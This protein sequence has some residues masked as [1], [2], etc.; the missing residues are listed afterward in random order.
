[1]LNRR[2]I[3]GILIAICYL[4]LSLNTAHSSALKL[5]SDNGD[6][7]IGHAIHYLDDKKY[8][9][10]LTAENF[11]DIEIRSLKK[12]HASQFNLVN[13]DSGYWLRVDLVSDV[14]NPESW[15]LHSDRALYDLSVYSMVNNQP[16]TL[17]KIPSQLQ[18][19]RSV[20]SFELNH[21]HTVSLLIHVNGKTAIPL[22]V[23]EASDYK[24]AAITINHLFS[25]LAGLLLGLVVYNFFLY[26][27][28]QQ[29]SY[30]YYVFHLIFSLTAIMVLEGFFPDVLQTFQAHFNQSYA[31]ILFACLFIRSFMETHKKMPVA[32]AILL[33]ISLISA[34]LI[35]VSFEN[36]QFIMN[37]LAPGMG[38]LAIYIAI[39]N[40]SK[41]FKPARFFL[42]GW[43]F[44]IISI[45]LFMFADIGWI[46]YSPAYKYG[47]FL[48]TAVEA[49]LFS[50][51]LAD[52]MAVLRED[53][54]ALEKKNLELSQNENKAKDAFLT[55]VNH[56][57]RTPLNAIFG[58]IQSLQPQASQ[59]L[60]PALKLIQ[61]GATDMMNLI[62]DI[63]SYTEIQAEKVSTNNKPFA[64]KSELNILQEF[65]QQRCCEKDLALH[66]LVDEDVPDWLWCDGDKVIIVLSK[67]LDNAVKFTEKGRIDLGIQYIDGELICTIKDSGIGITD[68][69]QQHIYQ[70]FRQNE[71]GFHRRYGGLG[72]GLSI[73]KQLVESMRGEIRLFSK[74]NQGSIFT[75]T[76]PLQSS[77][78]PL[79]NNPSS[80]KVIEKRVLVVED[81]KVNQQVICK[82]LDIL[83]YKTVIA[84]DGEQALKAL[85]DN[86][87]TLILMD[88]QMPVMDGFTCSQNIRNR[89]DALKDI[90]IIA[91]TAN[92][93]D[94]DRI[95]CNA[96]GMNEVLRKPVEIRKLQ[97]TLE[98]YC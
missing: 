40:L 37:I 53:K 2:V 67:L 86:V 46:T 3:H 42:L 18:G 58:G 39:Y 71:E 20:Y 56:E 28:L 79:I 47:Y 72:I 51:A 69:Q 91:V 24:N 13:M 50:L 8:D 94:A 74:Q 83:G 27:R 57:L 6:Y 52:R 88:L 31:S 96:S 16:N 32:D 38:V 76:L 80:N 60:S 34:I 49:L 77:A 17:K 19:G 43:I 25:A 66:W 97:N 87:I 22:Y 85:E 48:G 75:M 90:P 59:T 98:T 73:C 95:R 29:A 82:L 30:L 21:D 89:S 12:N 33:C 62:N 55:A 78:A 14:P 11:A 23:Q 5:S 68:V 61:D 15:F 65:Y 36:S 45:I 10:V 70:P 35:F 84:N 63:L 7:A 92:L 9:A 64:I 1:M 4:L 93:I 44:P 81:N 26:L 54:I 41:G